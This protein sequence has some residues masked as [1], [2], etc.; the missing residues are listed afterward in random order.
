MS[1]GIT[2]TAPGPGA[3]T[4]TRG[5]RVRLFGRDLPWWGAILIV[6]ASS[7]L[8][9]TV[10]ML[11]L[12]VAATV[13]GWHF[14]SSRHDPTF[15]TFSSSWDGSFYQRIAT[16]GYPTTLPVDGSGE[17]E[18]NAWAFLPLYPLVVRALMAM[19]GLS[20][21]PAGVLI[22]VLCGAGAALVL[23]RVVLARGG[24]VSALWATIFFC[25]GPLSFVL[26]ITYAE[27]M[28]F[29]LMFG[30]L[31]AMIRRR[32]W[33][34]VPLTVAAAFAKPGALAIPLALA[35][36]FVVRLLAD[37]RGRE[38]FPRRERIAVL[39]AGAVTASAGLAWP[40]IASAATGAPDA[41]VSTELSWWTGFIG[42][43]S[44]VPL[45]PWFLFTW[46]YA[47]VAG[48]LLVIAALAG[49][50]WVL[51]RRG[52]RALGTEVVAYAASYGLYLV[53]VFL[54]Q[55]SLFRLLLPLAPLGGARGLTHSPRARTIALAVGVALQPVALILLWFLGYP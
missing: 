2:S 25:F 5:G 22:A 35:V 3:G 41:Y 18:Q 20:F 13:G 42:H 6:Y 45:T 12:Y 7:R 52:V 28:F 48:V 4:R 30:G 53:A 50:V 34:V 39:V 55:Q 8:L 46:K 51:T 33:L 44:F 29:L 16:G 26:Q 24:T 1:A 9:T 32:Y 19:T 11:S 17:V 47:G 37:R 15:F 31:L 40:L 49:F 36:V 27:S 23:Y 14:A 54:P 10:F 38:E 21:A 43:V